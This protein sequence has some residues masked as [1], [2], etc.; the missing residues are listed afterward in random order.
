MPKIDITGKR[1]KLTRQQ[2]VVLN[3]IK[4]FKHEHEMP[5]TR[6]EMCDYF[7]WSSTNSAKDHLMAL[8][9]K[10]HIELLKGTSRGIRV[11]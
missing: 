6:Q 11:L 2:M 10:R 1:Q 5:P 3:F 7:G 8:E 4:D 9:S